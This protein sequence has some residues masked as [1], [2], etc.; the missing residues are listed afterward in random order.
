MLR[1]VWCEGPLPPPDPSEMRT[2]RSLVRRG[3][4]R[5]RDRGR[6]R[7]CEPGCWFLTARATR[8]LGQAEGMPQPGPSKIAAPRAR[9][10]AGEGV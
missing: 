6:D 5:T 1:R 3:L 9:E 7:A 8:L 2:V 4:L 10:R